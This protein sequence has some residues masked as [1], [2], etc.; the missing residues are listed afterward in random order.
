MTS[1]RLA[2]LTT[3]RQDWGLLRPLCE[4]LQPDRAFELLLIAGGMACS[5]AH[6][7][8]VGQI[9]GQGFELAAELAWPVEGTDAPAQAARALEMVASTLSRLEPDALVLLGDRYETAA[10][11]LAAT[12][13]KVPIVHLYGG[14]ETEGA[15]DNSLRHCITKLS[16]LHLVS[17]E[18]YANRVIQMGENRQNVHVVGSLG[19]DNALSARRPS[20]ADLEQR[21]G[22]QLKHPLGVVT[23]H[24]TTL[25][26]SKRLVELQA[27]VAVIEKFPAT[28]VVTLPNADPGGE[29]IRSAF[30]ELAERRQN[31]VAVSALGDEDYLGVMSSADFVLGNSS[32]GMT[33]APA[34]RVPTINV[35][36]RQRGRLRCVSILDVPPDVT[37]VM[38]AIERCLT[39]EFRRVVREMPPPYGGG[40]VA[41]RVLAVLKDWNPP[42]PPRKV[43]ED[44]PEAR[45]VS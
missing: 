7:N 1:L 23:L 44:L 5:H 29:V 33:E 42:E 31:I 43:F 14:E 39:P 20:Q 30:L 13:A 34:L 38:T 19:V 11:A 3:G 24:P 45:G 27:V 8:V 6:G 17:H 41:S 35:G 9:R 26:D 40:G 32:S 25:A 36:D 16:H 4:L 22:I 37:A 12:L 15:F 2:V 28:W 21:L 18:V 10:A